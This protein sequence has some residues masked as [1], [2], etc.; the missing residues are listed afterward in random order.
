MRRSSGAVT[1]KVGRG[2]KFAEVGGV[3]DHVRRCGVPQ[4]VRSEA[5]H[6]GFGDETLEGLV[7]VAR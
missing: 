2:A 6:S 5:W 7:E 3:A 1:E 4:S